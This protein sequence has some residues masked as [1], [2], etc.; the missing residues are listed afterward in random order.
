MSKYIFILSLFFLI[1]FPKEMKAETIHLK[2]GSKV[3]GKITTIEKNIVSVET[4]IGTLKIEKNKIDKIEY[5]DKETTLEK[6]V[7]AQSKLD[8][9]LKINELSDRKRFD[10][11][12]VG[13]VWGLTIVGDLAAGEPFFAGSA[14]P[15]VGPFAAA[16]EVD[17]SNSDDPDTDRALFLLSGAIQTAFFIDFLI[18]SKEKSDL[19][20][21]LEKK[22]AY[23]VIPTQNGM[24][25]KFTY[26][27]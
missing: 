24:C 22:Y 23:T 9:R 3:I 4:E 26:R 14:V 19:E 27:F 5:V 13:V 12:G 2:D 15:V 8:L 6:S 11:I 7:D 10:L 20:N 1:F 16:A 18:T 21:E 17:E 25:A